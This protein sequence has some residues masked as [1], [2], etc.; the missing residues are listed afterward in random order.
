L[1]GA[2][3]WARRALNGPKRQFPARAV[4]TLKQYIPPGESFEVDLYPEVHPVCARE[5]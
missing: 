2:F 3:V 4:P 5:L 1:Y